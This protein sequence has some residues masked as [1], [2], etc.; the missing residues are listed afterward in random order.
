VDFE[1]LDAVTGNPERLTQDF[2][3]IRVNIED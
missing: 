1:T 2:G 3:T